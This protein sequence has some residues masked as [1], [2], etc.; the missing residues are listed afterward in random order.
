MFK[1]VLTSLAGVALAALT[2]AVSAAPDMGAL[3]ASAEGD[4]ARK[5]VICDTTA[6]L[7]TGP[8][9]NADK[10]YVRRDT[11][12]PEMLLPP[13]FVAGGAFYTERFEQLYFKFRRDSQISRGAISQAQASTGRDLIAIYRRNG[14]LPPSYVKTQNRYCTGLA[15]EN[16]VYSVN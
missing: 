9:L 15:R 4:A 11:G 10:I 2:T 6:F 1:P 14:S 3:D 8:D 13:N 16:G 12:V 7:G 5:L